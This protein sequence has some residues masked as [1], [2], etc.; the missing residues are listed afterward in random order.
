[1]LIP[2]L[3]SSKR[4]AVGRP[5]GFIIPKYVNAG[6]DRN[7]RFLRGYRFDGDGSQ[8]LYG[9]AFLLPE[10]GDAWR[11]RVRDDIPYYFAIGA[12]GEC[13]PRY[14]NYVAL[15]PVKKDAWGIPA[16]HIHASYGQNEHAMAAAM[17]DD[18][19]AIIDEMKLSK[20]TPPRP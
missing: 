16:L 8:E 19:T 1:G 2:S 3:Q 4:E 13:L 20:I 17:R 7:S 5:C 14:D 18:I 11:K 9:H 12:Q 15:D 6:K 10:F